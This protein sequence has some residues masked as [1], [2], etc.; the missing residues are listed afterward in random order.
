MSQR[1][2]DDGLGFFLDLSQ[3]VLAEEALGVNLVDLF[4]ARRTRRKPAIFG[5]HFDPSDRTAV[6]R[7]GGQNLLDRLT[8]N[9]AA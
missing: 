3:V 2:R 6:S 7:S 9:S 1:F 5:D 4:R 8:S